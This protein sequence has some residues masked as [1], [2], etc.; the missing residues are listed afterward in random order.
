M[1]QR[2]VDSGVTQW[3][4]DQL[5]DLTGK[6]YVITGGNSGIGLEAARH[7]ARAGGDVVIAC[8]SP[9]KAQAAQ[10]DLAA[11]ARGAVDVLRLDLADLS[12][13]RDAAAELRER[14]ARIDGLI[15]NA[16]VMQT[17]RR[18]TRDGFELQLGV[19]HIGHFVWTKLLLDRVEAAAGRV[20]VV[21]SLAHKYGA[22]DF[23]DLMMARRYA[24]TRSY[25]RSKLANLMFAFELDRRLRA[26]GARSMAVA[27]HP[28]YSDTRLQ[29][30]GPTGFFHA[31]YRVTNPLLA[32]SAQAGAEPTV[33]AAAGR[34]AKPGGYYGP[35][36]MGEVRGPAGDATVA[37]RARDTR[38]WARLWSAT[39]DALGERFDVADALVASL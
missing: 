8:R 33:L 35:Q 18:Q 28:G 29:S 31:L 17:P 6:L 32:Q 12:V 22:I 2:R 10:R 16:G 21:S 30:T 37:N 4:P 24:P 5:P 34:E 11:D 36:H 3:S 19:N 25:T 9:D 15:N 13:V 7:L 14:S 23:D 20:V 38:A 27:C 39:E 1:T 26:A